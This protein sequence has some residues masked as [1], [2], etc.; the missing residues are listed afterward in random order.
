MKRTGFHFAMKRLLLLFVAFALFLPSGIASA[1][2]A[3]D[4]RLNIQEDLSSISRKAPDIDKDKLRQLLQQQTFETASNKEYAPGE[5]VVQF[6]EN[7]RL[8]A[9][10]NVHSKIGATV[11]RTSEVVQ[12][13]QVVLLPDG[14]SVEDGIKQYKQNPDVL[15]AEPNYIYHASATT[16]NDP[17][18]GELWGLEKIQAP[19]A[20]DITTG[21]EDVIIAV[22]DSGVD[23]NHPDLR[24]N[25]WRK[26]GNGEYG[27]DFVELDDDPQDLNGHGTHVAGTI[28]AAGNNGEGIAGVM[29]NARIMAVRA[30]DRN[31]Q[32]YLSDI[33]EAV[34]YAA[35]NGAQII[36]M[37][38][39]GP[40]NSEILRE[41]IEKA[42]EQNNVLVIAAAGNES[43]NNDIS[44]SYPASYDLPNIIAVA[45][46][47]RDDKLAP[48][49]NYGATT[50]DVAAP[51]VGILSTYP[52]DWG[53]DV[54]GGLK[55]PM[56]DLKNWDYLENE[57]VISTEKYSSAPS[58][59]FANRAGLLQLDDYYLAGL[60]FK[61]ALNLKSIGGYIQLAFKQHRQL[62]DGEILG[63]IAM[64]D[65]REMTLVD[66]WTGSTE[67]DDF[68]SIT[69]DLDHFAKQDGVSF[70]FALLLPQKETTGGVYID[71]VEVIVY[72]LSQQA[73][74]YSYETM[75][76]TSMATPHVAGLAGLIKA[77]Y[78]DE[79]YQAIKKRI[80]SN[81]DPVPSLTGKVLTGGRINAYKALS[82]GSGEADPE[83]LYVKAT[84]GSD[85]NDGRSWKQAFATLQKALDVADT[86]LGR[87]YEIWMAAGTYSPTKTVGGT[88][89][90]Y[91]TFQMK[92]GVAIYGGFPADA[93]GDIGMD[94]RDWEANKT[95]LS[96]NVGSDH[97]YH[98]FYHPA[99][100]GLDD[101]AILDGVTIEG[102]DARDK[103]PFGGG[104]YNDN[105]SP[106]LRNVTISGNKAQSYGGG[107]FNNE[108][109]PKLINVTIHNSEALGLGGGVFNSES[110][111]ALTNV[112]ISGNWAKYAGGMFNQGSNPVLTNVTISG[113]RGDNTGGMLNN[114]SNPTIRN[115][116]IWGN[117]DE[118]DYDD[119]M[120][121]QSI[122]ESSLVGKPNPQGPD[123]IDLA[124]VS[125][126]TLFVSPKDF[127]EAP[128]EAGDYRLKPGSPAIDKGNDEFV[129]GIETDRDGNP[130]IVGAAVDLGAYE[131]QNTHPPSVPDPPTDVTAQAGDG[132]AT[133][134]FKAPA[135][136]G[137][138]AILSYTV[139]AWT[140]SDPSDITW[141]GTTSPIIVDRLMNNMVYEFT[142]VA[143]NAIGNSEPST[144]SN[145]VVPNSA[146]RLTVIS[147]DPLDDIT[148]AYGTERS[149]LRLPPT[150]QVTLS[151]HSTRS[152]GVTWDNGTPAYDGNTARAYTFSGTLSPEVDNPQNVTAHVK[153]IVRPDADSSN[154]DL[155]GLRLSSGTLSPAF[156]AGVTTYTAKVGYNVTTITVTPTAA[157]PKATVEV[158]DKRVISGQA[159]SPIKLNVGN[160]T[161]TVTVTAQDGS[162]QHYTIQVTRQPYIP[163]Y[164]PVTGVTLEPTELTV[165]AGGETAVLHATVTPS[166][167]TNPSVSWS[168]DNPEV[169]SVDQNGMVTPHKAGE[170][171]ITVTTQDGNFT[172][173]S[174]VKVEPDITLVGLKASKDS[175]LLK[176]G[177]QTSFRVYAVY[178]DDTVKNITSNQKTSYK[179]SSLSMATVKSGIIK[180]GKK[181]G[182][183]LITV[184]YEDQLLQIPVTVSKESVK[185]L[186]LS[187]EQAQLETGEGMQLQAMVTFSDGT[188]RDVTNKAVWVSDTPELL[189][190]KNGKLTAHAAGKATVT[191]YYAGES[192][193]LSVQVTEPKEVKRIS[194][195]KRSM[196]LIAD[197]TRSV[198][199]TAYYKDG[200][201]SV[202]TEKA[203][204]SSEDESVAVAKAGTI[205]AVGAGTTTVTVRYQGKAL[206]IRVTV[207][208]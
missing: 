199:L 5:L 53:A 76:G 64:S 191:V 193:E 60:Q 10:A 83:R 184:R 49:S 92:N 15:Y 185:E 79:G 31:G 46:T 94:S 168:S 27:Y 20:W 106:V 44:P 58:S 115:S 84:G 162:T 136:D 183:A 70:G 102:G 100:L 145:R 163:S 152:H 7:R 87:T 122:I 202:V 143:T 131:Y 25:M 74:S 4:S 59:A 36:N 200:S 158:D 164:Y 182:D 89:D 110:N 73:D 142:V 114:F 95:I 165:T 112:L 26:N 3:D 118:Y 52:H 19:A 170:A 160:N 198:S 77:K 32:G 9:Q 47:D 105:N 125:P 37:S 188:E 189:T 62:N 157:D 104:M 48:F 201:K 169:A 72:T 65:D 179:S 138:S 132:K 121:S 50:V 66:M 126:A 190:V 85:A 171:I 174:L 117:G 103:S 71:D 111:P 16:P 29:W 1:G 51:G 40:G 33:A 90:W 34:A 14:M 86:A 186:R 195:S 17:E 99:G 43:N 124:K 181:E 150:V 57:W 107:V 134:S 147:A 2:Q 24:A 172:A 116:I 55:D 197:K 206:T 180:A 28:A 39:G 6:G 176:P 80:M 88:E 146:E 166:Y 120:E 139:T 177:K 91:K 35:N 23:Y 154:A 45:A 42:G 22:V 151:D 149:A 18:Y 63:L 161:I 12:G 130:R 78:P 128:T 101:S 21:S 205:T 8:L 98:V 69:V 194:A 137:G 96:G 38:L 141:S 109:N 68:E 82:A 159:S 13:L 41:A 133:V 54:Y 123:G 155:S 148:V 30:L 196:T 203:D 187:A 56:D 167:A 135:N 156:D 93:N 97:V 178:S 175:V 207:T 11:K 173:H 67:G 75:N 208:K 192:A 127:S 129:K 61:Y 113:N 153:V 81:V 204:W 119:A 140:N 144:P 108:S